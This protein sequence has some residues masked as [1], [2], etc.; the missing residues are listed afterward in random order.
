MFATKAR[1]FAIVLVLAL[2]LLGSGSAAQD[3]P[4]QPNPAVVES[5]FKTLT[6]AER[7]GQLF[8]VSFT[9]KDVT[10]NSDIAELVQ[11]YRVGGVLV[12]AKNQNFTND[13]STPNQVLELT[14][15]LQTLAQNPPSAQLIARSVAVTGTATITATAPVTASAV[16][17]GPHHSIPLFIA[18]EHEGDGFPFT[19]IRDNLPAM[20]SL[21]ALGATWNT[22]YTRQ[23]G[24]AVGHDLALLGVN[25]LLGPSLDVLDTPRPTQGRGLGARTFGGNPYWVGE[26]GHAYIAGVHEGSNNRVLTIAQNFPGFGSSDREINREVPTI[27]K[28]L[29]DLRQVE[30]PPFFRV[31]DLAD[32]NDL[33]GV[34]DGVMTVHARYQGLSGNVPISLDARNLP[35]ILALKEIAPWKD[36]GGLVLSAPLGVP[37]AVE[38]MATGKDT[39]PAR[40]L[41]QDAFL[42]GSDILQLT[43]FHFTGQD[44]TAELANIKDVISFFRGKYATDPN[45][46]AVVDQRVKNIIKAKIKIFGLDLFKAQPQSKPDVLASLGTTPTDLNQIARAGVTL[47]TPATRDGRQSSSNPPQPDENILI[48]VDDRQGQDCA[49]C[50]PFLLIETSAIERKILQ[51]FGP[52]ATGQVSPEQIT[53]LGF[54]ELKNALSPPQDDPAATKRAANTEALIAKA[55]WIIFGMLNIDPDTVPQSDA[56]RALL[57]NR[58]DALRN[59]KLVLF[60]FNAPY[61]LDETEISQLTAYYGLYSKT[62]Y[63]LEAAARLL[64]QQFAPNG[65]SPVAIPAIGPLDL[66]PDP[67]QEID[68][69]PEQITGVSGKVTAINQP[70]AS[71][72]IDLKVGESILFR[73]GVIKDRNANP[74]PD[75]TVVD[76]FRYY[77]LEGL[78]LE[79]LQG[80]TNA[81]VAEVTIVKERDTPLQ[82]RASSNLAVQ[83]VTFNIGPGI[84][85]TPTP[86]A[87]PTVN[88][89][90]TATSTPAPTITPVEADTS[91]PA[92]AVT[93]TPAFNAESGGPFAGSPVDALDLVYSLLGSLLIAG[94]AFMLGGERFPLEERV[95][96][97]LVPVATGLIGYI[98]YT[99]LARGFP[100]SAY[101]QLLAKENVGSHWVAP[102]VSILFAVVGVIVWHLKPGRV[103]WRK[104]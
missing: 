23:V 26:M 9:G 100:D 70:P 34:T 96:S 78:S 41:A 79:P 11:L 59:K 45:F 82:V 20:P 14:N 1:N 32:P 10:A 71:G 18:A 86:T 24:Q 84:V 47:I 17:T 89:T 66:N 28:S 21:M 92:P 40:R 56:V 25:V 101:I 51:L 57:R 60:A 15:G 77:P 46:Q 27:L 88:P 95:R 48:F 104:S 64:F 35:A 83:S 94:I 44:N 85:D 29:D 4:P 3:T 67:N 87:S 31:T 103:F 102:L 7:V 49:A 69:I 80:K 55:D 13:V 72:S 97:A 22:G 90:P 12:S 61:F 58:Y 37:A 8:M 52:N 65:A 33:S 38:G 63:Y 6:P 93:A 68:L 73:T 2:C 75:G 19:Q 91:T 81:G 50:S 42:A 16:I 5:I 30:L 62:P 74:V 53:S 54:S 36:A 76:F 39:F 99:I 98:A 43:D